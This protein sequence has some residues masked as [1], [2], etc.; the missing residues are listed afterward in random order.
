M[1]FITLSQKWSKQKKA[2]E[3]T[4]L[5][6][7]ILFTGQRHF[8]LLENSLSQCCFSNLLLL[9]VIND[10]C[11]CPCVHMT[12]M[13]D[14]GMGHFYCRQHCFHL[15]VYFCFYFFNFHSLLIAVTSPDSWTA[16]WNPQGQWAATNVLCGANFTCKTFHTVRHFWQHFN[17][18]VTWIMAT[19]HRVT[20]VLVDYYSETSKSRVNLL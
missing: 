19:T 18:A 11:A 13:S 20:A 2:K 14:S 16:D 9:I 15:F 7:Q 10:S 3:W 17:H 8:L 6:S 5:I 4:F 12:C 1:C